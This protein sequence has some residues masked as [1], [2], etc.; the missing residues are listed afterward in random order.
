MSRRIDTQSRQGIAGTDRDAI[1]FE[2]WI[3]FQVFQAHDHVM[4]FAI[5]R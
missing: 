3:S 4:M 5:I 1:T 2:H